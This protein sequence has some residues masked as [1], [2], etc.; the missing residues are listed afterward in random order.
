[1]SQREQPARACKKYKNCKVG[2]PTSTGVSSSDSGLAAELVSGSDLSSCVVKS[3]PVCGH[4]VA[5]GSQSCADLFENSGSISP[6]NSVFDWSERSGTH[7]L[8][9]GISDTFS[10]SV[11]TVREDMDGVE[12][13]DLRLEDA[14]EEGRVEGRVRD[15]GSGDDAGVLGDREDDVFSNRDLMRIIR[16]LALGRA[17]APPLAP[18]LSDQT[19]KVQG[20]A[21]HK[22]GHDIAKY[23]SK[24]EADLIDIGVPRCEFKS[25]LY[26][27]L[28]SK[29]ASQIVASIDRDECSYEE[30]K[31]TLIESLGS[32]KTSLGSKLMTEFASDVR[33]M[34]PLEKYVHLKG[35]M[36]SVS[37]SIV[38][39]KDILLFF[40][41]AIYR[42]SSTSHQ[43]AIMDSRE[44][45]TFREL[46]KLAL[47]LHSSDSDRSGVSRGG[48]R[49]TSSSD[50][51]R[52]F[53]CQRLGHKSFECR[54]FR[55]D[56]RSIVCYS[57]QQP[58][59]KSPDCPNKGE[60][61]PTRQQGRQAEVGKRQLGLKTGNKPLNASCAGWHPSCDWM[62]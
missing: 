27:K 6:E 24:L 50:V 38:E 56:S 20:L 14:G 22:E 11:L 2:I 30:L 46:N 49:G 40:A 26:Q 37:M 28:A 32:G 48:G 4:S 55:E 62:C 34:N 39:R 7:R 45:N 60:R 1:M 18:S 43:K 42:S 17:A 13:A 19:R 61:A 21:H 58:G 52:C 29:S 54:S 33:S 36:D 53:K 23:I 15:M 47:S 35:L 3:S 5:S 51:V 59:H 57:C 31:Q 10:G 16:S 25:I 41:C 12:G 44:I 8:F 9:G